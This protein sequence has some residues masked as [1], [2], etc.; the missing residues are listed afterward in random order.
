MEISLE[1]NEIIHEYNRE[2]FAELPQQQVYGVS[3][4]PED[5]PIRQLLRWGYAD[6]ESKSEQPQVG[7]KGPRAMSEHTDEYRGYFY[8]QAQDK[9]YQIR[10][11]EEPEQQL[12]QTEA[13]DE[14]DAGQSQ[15]ESARSG[16]TGEGQILAKVTDG[17]DPASKKRRE[18][19]IKKLHQTTRWMANSGFTT[20]FGK[21]AFHNYG[22]ANVKPTYGGVGYGQYLKS[23]NVHP[24]LGTSQPEYHQVHGNAERIAQ[25]RK[26]LEPQPPRKCK[27]EDRFTPAQIEEIKA[28]APIHGEKKLSAGIKIFAAHLMNS[29]RFASEHNTPEP[30]ID[31]DKSVTAAVKS[32]VLGKQAGKRPQTAKPAAKPAAK[33]P[34]SSQGSK[35]ATPKRAAHAPKKSVDTV[36]FDLEERPSPIAPPK[37]ETTDDF[38]KNEELANTEAVAQ[39]SSQKVS[40]LAA[41]MTDVGSG[42][43]KHFFTSYQAMNTGID[44]KA[45][46][47]AEV[48]PYVQQIAPPEVSQQL[49][50]SSFAPAVP[51]TYLGYIP[52]QERDPKNYK[53][54]PSPWTQRI[55][56]AGKIS[57]KG[58]QAKNVIFYDSY[59]V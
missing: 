3:R 55:P 31:G 54:L 48:L 24:H 41:K 22:N 10:Q 15:A 27:E 2:H 32:K 23:H 13:V 33:R 37:E 29:K 59:N 36:E 49:T 11:G 25:L 30:S 19:R 12:E 42:P 6:S 56:I 38:E 4:R 57:H 9:Y 34:A 44:S 45:P 26:P 53:H 47:P 14:L 40:K 21:P 1:P 50:S 8:S 52:P 17:V 43:P 46:K 18:Q 51:D 5:P 16:Q 39:E 7:Q 35:Q 58:P 20:Y 28:R